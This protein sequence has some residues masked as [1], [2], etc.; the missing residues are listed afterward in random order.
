MNSSGDLLTGPSVSLIYRDESGWILL[1]DLVVGTSD[2]VARW[3]YGFVAYPHLSDRIEVTNRAG[4]VREKAGVIAGCRSGT[5]VVLTPE[6]YP[7]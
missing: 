6:V 1:D 4:T 3:G 5:Y 7:Q 2:D